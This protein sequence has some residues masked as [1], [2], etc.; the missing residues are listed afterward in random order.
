[1]YKRYQSPPGSK[2]AG[3]PRPQNHPRNSHQDM[4]GDRFQ[5]SYNDMG[6][7]HFQSSYQDM[8]GNHFQGGHQDM[9]RNH[10]Q[11]G[12]QDTGRNYSQ[13][14]SR[15]M[16][17]GHS[18]AGSGNRQNQRANQNYDTPRHNSNDNFEYDGHRDDMNW[19][20]AADYNH[21]NEPRGAPNPPAGGLGG[22]L[23]GLFGGGKSGGRREE[24]NIVKSILSFIRPGIYNTETKKIL[25]ILTAEDL[26]LAALILMIADSD[27]NDDLALLIALV[28]IFMA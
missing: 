1:M 9:G 21:R 2:P 20:R 18:N 23:S 25:G 8:G 15:N 28:Y 22:L 12:H 11:S 17:S 5:N 4:G 26:L 19:N 3:N 24:P 6:D 10:S 16:G 7:N 27:E 13:S 14:S